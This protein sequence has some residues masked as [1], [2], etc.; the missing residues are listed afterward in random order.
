M[1]HTRIFFLLALLLCLP[2][3]LPAA[4][5][6]PEYTDEHPLVVVCDWDFRPFEFLDSEGQPAGYNIEVLDMIFDRLDIPHKFV[7]Q[8]W[9]VATNMFE[10]HEADLI[11]ALFYFYKHHPYVS[12]HKYLNYYNLKAVRRADVAPIPPLRNLKSTDTIL[13]KKDDYAAMSIGI[14]PDVN[15]VT[16]FHTPKDALTGI[17]TGKYKYFIWGEQ[18]LNRKIQE[19]G[20]DSLVLDEVAIPAGELRIIGYNRNLIEIIDDQYTRLEQAGDLQKI[21]DRWFH[22][23]RVHDDTSPVALIVFVALVVAVI[24]VFLLT[25]LVTRR[26]RTTVQQ[27]SDLGQMMDQVLNMGDYYVVEWDL[28]TNLLQNKYRDMLPVPKMT[29]EDFMKRVPPEDAQHLHELDMQ[30]TAGAISS[31]EIQLSFNPGTPENPQWRVFYGNAII[32]KENGKPV[33]IVYTGKDIT[34]EVNEERHIQNLANKYKKMFDTNLIAMSFYDANGRLLDMNKKMADLCEIGEKNKKFF[35]GTSLFDFPD[36]KGVYM[37][38]TREVLHCCHHFFEPSLGLDKYVEYRIY[39]IISDDNRLVY[40]IATNRDI[41]AERNMYL[42]QREHDRKLQAT[43][44][45]INRYERQLH[46]LLEET[47]MYIWTYRPSENA[48][49]MTRSPGVTEFSETVEEYL[50]TIDEEYRQQAAEQITQAMAAG[51]AYTTIMPFASTPLDPNHSWYS[52]SGMPI[53]DKDGQLK[54]YFGLA[55]NVTDLMEAQQKLRVETERAENSGRLKAAFLANMTHEIRTPLNAIVGFSGLLQSVETDEERHEFIRIIRNNCDMLL[56][57]IND[58]L[59]ASNMGQSLAFRTEELDLAIVFDDICQSLAQ[60][61]EN[62]DVEFQKDSPYPSCPATLD[63][64]RLMQLLTNFVTNAVKYTQEGHIR[65]GY[66]KEQRHDVD[67][68]YFYCEDTGVGI[69]KE[70]QA[71]VFQRFVKLNDFVQGTGLGLAI[72]KSIIDRCEGEIGVTGDEGIGSTFWFWIPRN[73]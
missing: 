73:L 52:V 36:I 32:E 16:E 3:A 50:G 8:E 22:P 54:E 62:P 14:M 53:F 21:Y 60:R 41:T 34:D 11:H 45:A 51:K 4:N 20:I 55:R 42:K 6:F 24:F 48:V 47:Q 63:K 59:E 46:Y 49:R 57:L 33:N 28:R 65:V 58:I 9:H 5:D 2:L 66:R 40:Y 1:K 7:M 56:R 68:L 13:V 64:G 10:R 27:R 30:L 72:C 67:G 37:P 15:F 26:V 39:P 70:K 44:D 38:G 17:R 18:P 12:T 69:P 43:N 29:P 31:F 35:W 71:S 25:R 19:L 23:E 61:V